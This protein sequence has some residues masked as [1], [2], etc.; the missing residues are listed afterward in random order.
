MFGGDEGA[1]ILQAVCNQLLL[2]HGMGTGGDLVDH[3]PGEG[4]VPLQIIEV[5][6][7]D[8]AVL[9]PH[10]GNFSHGSLQLFTV[11]GAVVHADQRQRLSAGFP[12]AQ[13]H[14][15]ELCHEASAVFWPLRHILSHCRSQF[16]CP[17]AQRIAFFRDGEGYHLQRRLFKD[18]SDPLAVVEH[19]KALGHGA[20]HFF[21]Q[22]AVR[23]QS[24]RYG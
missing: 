1:D 9:Q 18:L 6:L 17:G 7:C 19:S 3:A 2:H 5:L 8:F 16:P 24:H 4:N 13:T 11:V 20:Y 12:S 21:L 14:G 22:P 23:I 10:F 15:G